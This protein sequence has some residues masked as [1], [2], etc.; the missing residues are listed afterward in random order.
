MYLLVEWQL[1]RVISRIVQLSLFWCISTVVRTLRWSGADVMSRK[2]FLV[3]CALSM[4]NEDQPWSLWLCCRIISG[5]R[6]HLLSFHFFYI[7]H[8]RKIKYTKQTFLTPYLRYDKKMSLGFPGGTGAK[9]PTC[10]CKR[11]KRWGFDPW[12]GR[13]PGEGNG[14]P[15]QYFCLE[16]LMDRGVQ[17]ATVHRVAKSWTWLKRLNMH[18]KIS[19]GFPGGLV[20]KNL[21]ADAGDM[22]ST[23]VPGRLN[24]LS[25]P[26][27]TVEP[28]FWS[29]GAATTEACMP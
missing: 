6:Q 12:L 21:P 19:L 7:I 13:C 16:N 25:K 4:R 15:F 10:P 11:H 2:C 18:K 28:V 20:V 29:L 23:P 14:K 17:W 3:P 27:T 24:M 8:V 5:T 22:G 9:E 1:L 26:V